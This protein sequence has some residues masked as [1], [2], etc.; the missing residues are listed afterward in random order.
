M[1]FDIIYCKRYVLILL[2]MII[3]SQ[4]HVIELDIVLAQAWG[5]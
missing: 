1:N 2:S 3:T 4:Q 5:K